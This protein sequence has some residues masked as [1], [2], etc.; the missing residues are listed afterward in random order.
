VQSKPK[1]D[2]KQEEEKNKGEDAD[3]GGTGTKMALDEGRMGKKDST[4]ATG[5]YAMKNNNADPQLAREQAIDEAK[6]SGVLGE[7]MSKQGGAF[8]SLTGTADFSSGLE[9]QDI[10][11]GLLGNEH[12]EMA[13]G[14]GFGISGT[15]PGGGGTGWG[16][17]GTGRY[18]TIGHGSGTG[19]GF[20][21]G[22]G[23]GGLRGRKARAPQVQFGSVS[24]TGDLDK[25]I[26]RRYIRRKLPRIRNCYEK[27]L[28]ANDGLAG[29]VVTQFQ[30]TSD[31]TVQ[32]ASAGGM[33]NPKVEEC[34]ADA[35][36]SI[37][38]PKPKGGGRVNV[39]YPF[40]FRSSSE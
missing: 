32:G 3:S 15:G 37:Q 30:I 27:E 36:R 11:G 20:G 40:H 7:L 8:A 17:I 39:R 31:G 16:T 19:T 18:G 12:G 26:I 33:G 9:D 1:E 24:S 4:R 5:Q 22:S 13:G 35:I 21:S 34:V 6:R 23:T 14:F 38:F 10:Y 2:P 28:L 25:N 29:T